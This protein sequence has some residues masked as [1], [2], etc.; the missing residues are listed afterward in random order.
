MWDS[1]TMPW[2]HAFLEGWEAFVHGSIP[3]GAVITDES[4]AVIATGR[5]RTFEHMERNPRIAHAEIGALRA[6]DAA[7]F[8][9][10]KRYTLYTCMEPCPM[11][12][13]T[14]VMAQFRKVRIA[15]RDG[16]CGS[17][18]LCTDDPYMASKNLE[19]HFEGGLLE[20]VQLV[21]QIYNEFK[22]YCGEKSAVA[23]AFERDCPRAAELAGALYKSR[24]LDACVE[25]G[26]PFAE[27]F[28]Q[29]ALR[30]GD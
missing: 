17:T 18:H 4:G 16:Y 28:D 27:V 2:R 29:I 10:F 24:Y 25:K 7:K 9:D 3:I 5:N 13:G 6:L 11:C 22:R 21:L 20:A 15:A 19:I 12:M 30:L 23:R 14:I 26:M 1:V 8:P